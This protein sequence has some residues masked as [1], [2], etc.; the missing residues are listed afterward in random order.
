MFV[1]LPGVTPAEIHVAPAPGPA[2]T[3]HLR[4]V[5]AR[6]ALACGDSW[7]RTWPAAG[8]GAERTGLVYWDGGTLS[9]VRAEVSLWW[10]LLPAVGG[11]RRDAGPPSPADAGGTRR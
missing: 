4:V 5:R 6:W 8:V 2:G 10:V 11:E 7:L 3:P 1:L 9:H